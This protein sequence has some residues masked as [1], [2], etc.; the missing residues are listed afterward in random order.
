MGSFVLELAWTGR[1]LERRLLLEE[2]GGVIRRLEPLRGGPSPSGATVCSGLTIPGLCNGHSHCFH[3]ALRGRTEDPTAADFWSWRDRMY[4]LAHRL[5]PDSYHRLALAVYGEMALAGITTVGEFHYL[6]HRPDG[7]PY[8]NGEM[9][10]ALISA[11]DEAG[12]RL[13]L[14]DTC[15]LRPGFQ[16]GSLEGP[17]ARFSDGSA[18]AWV[19]RVN[20]IQ[21]TGR[22]V[23]G[24]AA[25]SVRALDASALSVVAG[26][27]RERGAPLHLHLSEQTGENSD[28]LAATGKT[29]TALLWGLG[30]LGPQTTAV[31]AIHLTADDVRLLGESGTGVCVCPTTERDLADGVCPAIDLRSAGSPL[32]L[33][34]DSNA[35]VDLF[36][37]ARAVELDQRLLTHRRGMHSAVDLLTAATAGGA[38]A[39]GW[40]A[41]ELRVGAKAD[42][43]SLDLES[44][45]L[46][47]PGIE[48]L[49]SRVV[50]AAA[51]SD[52]VTVVVDGQVVVRDGLHIRLGTAGSLLSQALSQLELA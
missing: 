26:W 12:I 40:D 22:L 45:R 36:E 23:I 25:H 33:G 31:H 20:R 32:C 18:E 7:G 15:Y 13:T 5:N 14:L 48:D 51:P 27:A 52:V 16:G 37:E 8:S 35:V 9:E 50:Y 42:F 24:A 43:V 39:L 47:G 1:D 11:A 19:T 10:A 17:S 6:H 21:P 46:A 28:C 41:G 4:R 44:T 29:P 3:R 30:L 34:T 38:G 49:I 2:S